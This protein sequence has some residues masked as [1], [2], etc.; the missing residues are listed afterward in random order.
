M[1]IESE[2]LL[3]E[4]AAVDVWCPSIGDWSGG[5]RLE[6]LQ[7][8]AVVVRRL[9]DGQVL[10]AAFPLDQVRPA[11]HPPRWAERQ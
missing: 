6:R 8:G 10:P 2:N 7:P 3:S 11:A 1:A 5:F 9:S 4:G